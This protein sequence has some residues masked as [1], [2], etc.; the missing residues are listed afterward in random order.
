MKEALNKKNVLK[1][2]PCSW[3]PGMSAQ[4]HLKDYLSGPHPVLEHHMM[5]S[6]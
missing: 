1:S 6:K 3:V 4:P 2:L 5:D